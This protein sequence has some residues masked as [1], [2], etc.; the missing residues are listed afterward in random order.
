MT[1]VA[2]LPFNVYICS[3][4]DID[5]DGTAYASLAT[6]SGSELYAVNLQTGGASYIG[7]LEGSP[8]HSI[9]LP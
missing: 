7:D 3:G 5:T 6:D 4:M 8:V 1:T 2:N 9:A